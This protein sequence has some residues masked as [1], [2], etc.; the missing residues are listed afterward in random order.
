[1]RQIGKQCYEIRHKTA[2]HNWR[3][4]LAV[5]SDIAVLLAEDKKRSSIAKTA[6]ET[7]KSRLRL[8]E[9]AERELNREDL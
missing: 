2:Q 6:I 9:Q 3:V 7:C 4:Y 8:Y 5:R 1:M